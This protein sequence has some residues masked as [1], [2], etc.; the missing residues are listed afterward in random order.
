MSISRVSIPI[1]VAAWGGGTANSPNSINGEVLSVRLPAAAVALTG[2]GGTCHL[3]LRRAYD[4]G[5]IFAGTIGAAPV[6]YQ[7]R[8][9]VHDQAGGTTAYA[10][11]VGP[12]ATETIPVLGTITAVIASGAPSAAGTVEILYRR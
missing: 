4:G 10:V 8:L 2:A 3:T 1:T 5:T 12:V 7:P 6:Q 11:G 9:P